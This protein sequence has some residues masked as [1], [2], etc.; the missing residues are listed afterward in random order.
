MAIIDLESSPTPHITTPENMTEIILNL[1]TLE[2]GSRRV[3]RSKVS[4]VITYPVSTTTVTDL[5]CY[6]FLRYFCMS[7]LT[8]N[9]SL[10]L[11]F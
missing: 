6:R 7:I 5:V 2:L 1:Y 11:R 4:P 9:S 10:R 8:S 3:L